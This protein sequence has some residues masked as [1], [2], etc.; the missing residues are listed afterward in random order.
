MLGTLREATF[1][2]QMRR[3]YRNS[4][5]PCFFGRFVARDGGTFIEG[6]FG[7]HP[8]VK[9]LMSFWFSFL[10]LFAAVVLFAPSV[11]RPAT[12]WE[13]AGLL[14]G[15]SGMAAFGV[16]IVRFGRWLGC[17]EERAI[18]DFLTRTLEAD[19]AA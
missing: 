8:A 12:T 13:R 17:G 4:F 16:G 3:G 14:L 6:D 5:A 11:G 9:V 10:V 19:A 18:V 2:L 15:A 1:R 7:L